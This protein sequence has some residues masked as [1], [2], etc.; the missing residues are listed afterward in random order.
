LTVVQQP[1]TA[2]RGRTQANL[3]DTEDSGLMR[4]WSP[5]NEA[6]RS[7]RAVP[8][9]ESCAVFDLA[10]AHEG[11]NDP[12]QTAYV[13]PRTIR[14]PTLSWIASVQG[15]PWTKPLQR[16]SWARVV[17]SPVADPATPR[18]TAATDRRTARNNCDILPLNATTAPRRQPPPFSQLPAVLNDRQNHHAFSAPIPT[19]GHP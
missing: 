5:L 14:G 4:H 11:P 8:R 2:V 17:G 9:R 12:I 7:A 16:S 19:R 10:K 15:A 3:A 6:R 13:L 18:A 1:P